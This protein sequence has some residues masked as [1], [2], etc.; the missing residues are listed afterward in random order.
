[1]QQRIL[2]FL[3]ILLL[4]KLFFNRNFFPQIKII[5]PKVQ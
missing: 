3:I 4:F 1:M 5:L 2:V